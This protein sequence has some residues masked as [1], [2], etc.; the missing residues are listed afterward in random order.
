MPSTTAHSPVSRISLR[1]STSTPAFFGDFW[2]AL[3]SRFSRHAVEQALVDP[4][5]VEDVGHDATQPCER[6]L[7]TMQIR[8][9]VRSTIGLGSDGLALGFGCRPG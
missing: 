5:D 7:G 3:A 2:M 9:I 8:D 4:R 1:T 6:L